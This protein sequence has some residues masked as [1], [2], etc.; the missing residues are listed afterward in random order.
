MTT[1]LHRPEQAMQGQYQACFVFE[2][3]DWVI[4]ADM[5]WDGEDFQPAGAVEIMDISEDNPVTEVVRLGVFY[6]KFGPDIFHTAMEDL[7]VSA[8]EDQE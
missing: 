2:G 4:A 3:H 7:T 1:T 6:D 8:K 5:E